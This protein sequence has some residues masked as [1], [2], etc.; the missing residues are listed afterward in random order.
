MFFW[1]LTY[2]IFKR[3]YIFSHPNTFSHFF[4]KYLMLSYVHTTWCVLC[5]CV[6]VFFFLLL[7]LY[8]DKGDF[9]QKE[10]GRGTW[11]ITATGK[12]ATT[13]KQKCYIFNC[14][15]FWRC[16]GMV[17]QFFFSTNNLWKFFT[18]QKSK[19]GKVWLARIC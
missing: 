10:K 18:H 6:C 14:A 3:L 2:N 12:T 5:V 15:L 11:T 7:F 8:M 1:F 17:K 4:L 9:A 13:K 16:R 19:N